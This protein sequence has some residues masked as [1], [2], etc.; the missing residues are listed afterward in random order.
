MRKFKTSIEKK[1]LMLENNLKLKFSIVCPYL[2]TP[3]VE[4]VLIIIKLNYFSSLEKATI[5]ISMNS[6]ME[7][8]VYKLL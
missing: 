1:L 4:I 3:F 7:Y 2:L 5:Y 8:K 6:F